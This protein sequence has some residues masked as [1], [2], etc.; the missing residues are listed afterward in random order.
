MFRFACLVV[1]FASSSAVGWTSHVE[2]R[3]VTDRWRDANG[4]VWEGGE[5]CMQDIWRDENGMKWFG[6]K[7][8]CRPVPSRRVVANRIILSDS[9]S[10]PT[11]LGSGGWGWGAQIRDQRDRCGLQPM[12]NSTSACP[13]DSLC[14]LGCVDDPDPSALWATQRSETGDVI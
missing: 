10:R 3:S 5:R 1:F 12:L 7:W 14:C 2:T 9:N 4:I 11:S 8:A 6:A 13:A